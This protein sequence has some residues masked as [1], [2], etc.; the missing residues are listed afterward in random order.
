VYIL[1]GIFVFI[2]GSCIGSFLN[3]CILR[4]PK[5]ESIIS[6]RSYCPYC[7]KQIFWYDNIPLLSYLFLRAR[8]R[9]CGEKI[10]FRYFLIE[11]ITA[12]LFLWTFLFF[13][14][15]FKFFFYSV[16]ISFL[17]VASFI[18]IDYRI[19]PDCVSVTGILVGLA[20]SFFYSFL[21]FQDFP[22]LF[23]FD[24]LHGAIAGAGICFLTAVIFNFI[25]FTLIDKFY[26]RVLK[27][28]FYLKE[29]FSS[30]EEPTV[31]GG[32]DIYLM[33]LIGAFLGF[34]LTLFSF[35]LAPFLGAIAG[36]INLLKKKTHLIPYG[37]FL[38]LG[39]IMSVFWGEKIIKF[40]IG[41]L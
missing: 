1:K 21:R 10:S 41:G 38:S 37:P 4:L 6:P 7:K 15:S 8:C 22:R 17:I 25:F 34:K 39:A 19:I 16:L 27:K 12:S 36:I 2:L 24:S 29:E 30:D 9:F 3:V 35:F 32:G 5:E 13:G 20:L 11:L 14:L 23:I 18:D 33:A 40:F 26:K 31:L 28:E